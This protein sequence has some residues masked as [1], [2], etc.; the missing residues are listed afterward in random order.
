MDQKLSALLKMGQ[1]QTAV[2]ALF[3]HAETAKA[4]GDYETARPIYEDYVA[5][6]LAY[7]QASLKFNRKFPE[8]PWDIPP[9]VQPLV[10]ALLVL[11]DLVQALGDRKA[12]GI[13][14]QEAVDLSEAHLGSSGSA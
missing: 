2:S 3:F 7:L 8:S 13:L 4:S 1:L 11:A 9:I 5:K 6:S 12:A 10:N 14:R